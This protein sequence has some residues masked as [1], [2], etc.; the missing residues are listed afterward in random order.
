M[1]AIIKGTFVLAAL[2]LAI[3]TVTA[4]ADYY[5]FEGFGGYSYMSL[6]R[7]IEDDEFD[8]V[9]SELPTNRVDAHG[10]NGSITYNF[11][12]YLGAKFDVTLH[13]FGED[14]NSI[15]TVNPPPPNQV[16]Q[17]FK[18]SQ[19]SYQY[20]GGVQFKD[21]AKEGSIFKPF[22]HALIGVAD[23]HYSIDQSN[24]NR[25]LDVNSTDWAFKFGGG[26]DIKVHKNIDIR[27]IGIDWNPIWRGDV[28]TN[29]QFGT[30][31]GTL[32]NNWIFNFGVVI[33]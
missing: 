22:G 9:F 5:K 26:L 25:L 29:T 20:M 10:F 6:N 30:V 18:T 33:H 23:Q 13:S 32:Q 7:G 3:S 2:F 4:Q 15:L 19:N 21:N 14:F 17:T 8:D 1:K 16:V 11:N 12:R 27:A 28:E 31:S 24:G